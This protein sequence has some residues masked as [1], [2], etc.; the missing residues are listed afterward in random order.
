MPRA[1]MSIKDRFQSL[2]RM[3]APYQ[4]AECGE[5]SVLLTQMHDYTGLHRKTLIRRMNGG[6]I[7]RKQRSRQ[8]GRVYD[9]DFRSAV[10]VI[11]DSLD[12]ICAERLRPA[13]LSTASHLAKHGALRLDATVSYKLARISTSQLRRVL[14]TVPRPACRL[15]K[16]QKHS[17][18]PTGLAATIPIAIIPWQ[19]VE[20][21]H[22][23]V[24]TVVHSGPNQSGDYLSTLQ[25]IDVATGWSEREAFLG[26]SAAYTVEALNT[27][28]KRCPIPWRHIHTDNG[29]EFLNSHFLAFINSRSSDVSLSRSRPYQKNDN[30]FV[31]QKNHSLVRAYFGAQRLDTP[32]QLR[33]VNSLY[34]DMWVYYNFFQPVQRQT[35]RQAVVDGHNVTRVRRTHD[36][37]RTPLDRLL[38]TGILNEAMRQ[39]LLTIRDKTNPLSLK[40]SIYHGLGQ[41]Q[42]LNTKQ[43]KEEGLASQVTISFGRTAKAR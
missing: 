42:R 20:P 10:R 41:L 29:Y 21:G 40:E 23:E 39:L 15:A 28:W 6:V 18:R 9:D 43:T 38:A 14:A 5:R 34:A 26:R 8:R 2:G 4:A 36:E 3:Y 24:D 37:A 25:M 12:W 35:A 16:Q 31:E 1:K 17:H 27:I 22:F 7:E 11:A 32:E 19:Q 30:R 13:L 33:L